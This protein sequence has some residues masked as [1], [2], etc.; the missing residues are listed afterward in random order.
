[1]T[2]EKFDELME[3]LACSTFHMSDEEARVVIEK[4]LEMY[5]E[6]LEVHDREWFFKYC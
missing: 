3:N 2:T 6:L 1:M 5:P 4:Y